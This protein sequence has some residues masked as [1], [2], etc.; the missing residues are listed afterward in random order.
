MFFSENSSVVLK[1]T[2]RV[3]N[4]KDTNIY[5]YPHHVRIGNGDEFVCG[6]SI[7]HEKAILTAAHCI[8]DTTTVRFGIDR[9]NDEV[10]RSANVVRTVIHPHYDPNSLSHDIAVILLKN[11]L[12]FDE[13]VHKIEMATKVGSIPKRATI[14]GWGCT[15]CIWFIPFWLCGLSP[16]S[17]KL[18]SGKLV[19]SK[20]QGHTFKSTSLVKS[21]PVSV[22]YKG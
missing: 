16:A 2:P 14:V 3:I 18:R 10:Y 6:G 20:Y 19:L 7:I 12:P 21:C 9:Y 22:L 8:T 4:G 1:I 15:Y 11:N 5:R 17:E 13:K